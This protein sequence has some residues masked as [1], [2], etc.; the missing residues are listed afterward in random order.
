MQHNEIDAIKEEVKKEFKIERLI[1][2]SD[3]VFA[4]VITLVAIEIKLPH[5]EEGKL[6]EELFNKALIHL[7]PTIFAYVVSFGLIGVLW[8]GHL[9]LFSVLKNYDGGLIFRNLL[10][11]FF[12]GLFPF[13]VSLTSDGNNSHGIVIRICI[14]ISIVSC[15][16]FS[17]HLLNRYI[18]ISKPELRDA[19]ADITEL[20]TTYKHAKLVSICMPIVSFLMIITSAFIE[21]PKKKIF[22]IYWVLPLFI[23]FWIK[24]IYMLRQQKLKKKGL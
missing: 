3:A 15:G 1:L 23:I 17:M 6:T 20:I 13:G 16:V 9:K 14:Y 24:G 18:L 19:D 10:F 22:A 7:L 11:L 8:Y 12:V 4:I 21:D 5:F 2:F